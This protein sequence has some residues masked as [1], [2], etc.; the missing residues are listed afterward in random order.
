[1]EATMREF[2]ESTLKFWEYLSEYERNQIISQ[3]FKVHYESKSIINHGSKDCKGLLIIAKGRGRIFINSENGSNGG[4]ITLYR[5]LEGDVCILSAACMMKGLD[6]NV[7]M[8]LEEDTEF[9]IVPKAVFLEISNRNIVVKNY[10]LEE[11]SD[12]FSSVMWV[13]NQYIFTNMAHRLAVALLEHRALGE[14]DDIQITHETLS[15]DLGTAREVVTRLLKQFQKDGL[16]ELNR[17][18]IKIM[19]VSRLFSI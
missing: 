5:L 2:L 4:E 8:E 18:N 15:K 6:I 19:D 12:K 1:M 10:L 14:S 11:I 16:V 3:T 17:G 9:L 7:S 13:L